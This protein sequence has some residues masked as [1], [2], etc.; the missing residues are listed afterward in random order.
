[1][2]GSRDR[3]LGEKLLKKFEIVQSSQIN[4]R[5]GVGDDQRLSSLAQS[6]EFFKSAGVRVPIFRRID[7]V[8][9]AA[10]L[11]QFHE[12]DTFETEFVCR[13]ARW[14]STVPEKGKDGFLSQV[15]L[16]AG[17]VGSVVINVDLYLQLH[18]TF[19]LPPQTKM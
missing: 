10:L 3:D 19:I 2:D 6:L 14:D 16:E 5:A 4:E 11:Q 9:N 18:H 12:S 17:L 13:L 7:D 8:G 1:M 15:F